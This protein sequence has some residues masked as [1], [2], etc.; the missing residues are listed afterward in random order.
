MATSTFSRTLTGLGFMGIAW[1][2]GAL[3]GALL[4]AFVWPV[5]GMTLVIGAAIALTSHHATILLGHAKM[6]AWL[7]EGRLKR[8][9][10]SSLGKHIWNFLKRTAM[11]WAV[12]TYG[13]WHALQP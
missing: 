3:S 8:T 10:Q 13:V 7:S 2:G 12:T 4:A 6:A 11:I 5:V 9:A 1:V